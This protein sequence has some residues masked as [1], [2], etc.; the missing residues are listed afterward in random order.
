MSWIQYFIG[1][2]PFFSHKLQKLFNTI[3]KL[4]FQNFPNLILTDFSN[5]ESINLLKLLIFPPINFPHY[6]LF[7]FT[8]YIFSSRFFF[9][10]S[11]TNDF[12]FVAWCRVY[13]LWPFLP[14]N[15]FIFVHSSSFSP[16]TLRLNFLLWCVFPH[17]YKCEYELCCENHQEIGAYEGENE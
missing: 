8:S 9:F 3:Q 4:H 2:L 17:I 11:D 16:N 6:C 7:N 5:R 10:Y 14:S 12:P 15:H 1:I 13:Q